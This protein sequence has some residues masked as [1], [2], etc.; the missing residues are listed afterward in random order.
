[1]VYFVG[2]HFFLLLVYLLECSNDMFEGGL[3]E[4]H[5]HLLFVDFQL[6]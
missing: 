2:D 1:L 6:A 4:V 5:F 3:T